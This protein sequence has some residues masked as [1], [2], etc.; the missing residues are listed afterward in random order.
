MITHLIQGLDMKSVFSEL[1]IAVFLTSLFVLNLSAQTLEYTQAGN[2]LNQIALGYPVPIPVDSITPVDG[3]RSYDSLQQRHQQLAEQYAQMS[4][5]QLGSTVEGRPV[6]GYLLSDADPAKASGGTEPSALINGGIHAREWQSP[7]AVTGFMEN[8]LVRSGDR[9]IH[10]Y[11]L[12]NVHLVIIPVLNI[13]GLIQTQRFPT[14][15]TS[16]EQTPRD[17]RMRRKNMNGVDTALN[18]TANNLLGVDLN[19]NNDPWWAS[20]D[21]SSSVGSSIVYHGT[22]AA[23]EPEI[24]ALLA[25]AQWAGEEQLAFYM[26]VHSFT[27]VYF[28]PNTGVTSRDTQTRAV[29]AA[30]RRANNFK[31]DYGPSS[32]GGGIGSTD[33]YFAYT[34]Q[35]PSYTLE[36]EPDNSAIEYGGNGVSHDGFILPESEVARMRLETSEATFAGLY[37]IADVPVLMGLEVLDENDELRFQLRWQVDDGERALQQIVVSSLAPS[38]SY[39]VRLHFNKPMRPSERN[40]YFSDFGTLT[41]PTVQLRYIING[42]EATIDL[43]NDAGTWVTGEGEYQQYQTDVYQMSFTAPDDLDWDSQQ[44]VGFDIAVADMAGSQLDS[45]PATLAVWQNGAW[46]H[47]EGSS[48]TGGSDTNMVLQDFADIAPPPVQPPTPTPTVPTPTANNNSGGGSSG[49][50]LVLLMIGLSLKPQLK[51]G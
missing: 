43:G 14:L 7:E 26:D 1:R 24:Q 31:Y 41:S 2:G 27:Q 11:I 10:Q 8:L 20:S 34:Y 47:Y 38:A 16:S 42:S 39:T 40:A 5:N 15:V 25:A 13:D 46:Q 17:G 30:M 32:A 12:E 23:S 37:A 19:R 18:T 22:G 33:E 28:A 3:F 4:A 50:L 6:W 29:A 48:N 49:Y 35:I 44:G 36:I 45:D 21:R 51:I 9:H